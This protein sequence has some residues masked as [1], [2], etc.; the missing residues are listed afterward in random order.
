MLTWDFK[1]IFHDGC[2]LCTIEMGHQYL[3]S[4]EICVEQLLLSWTVDKQHYLELEVKLGFA[5]RE[6]S[7]LGKV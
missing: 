4:D 3:V 1:I 5:H 2:T 7:C 6:V